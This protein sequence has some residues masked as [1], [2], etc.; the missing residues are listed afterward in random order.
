MSQLSAARGF[1]FR[2]DDPLPARERLRRAVA[3]LTRA[4]RTQVLVDHGFCG[5]L[6]GLVL[7]TVA[8]VAARL[9]SSPYPLW[10]LAGAAVVITL[11]IALLLGWRRRLNALDVAIRADLALKLK[12]RLSTAWEFMTVYGDNEL[13][14]RLAVQAVD[15]GLPDRPR[16]LFPLQV[17]RWGMLSPLA[18]AALLLASA[19]D[20]NLLHAPVPQEVDER[21]VG[22]GQRLGAFGRAMQE[23]ARRDELP[24]SAR[25]AAQIE[26][27]GARMEGGALSRSQALGE[28]RQMGDSL[29]Q[30]RTQALAEANATGGGSRH[31]ETRNGSPSVSDLNPESMLD[32]LRRGALDS[33]DTRALTGRLDDLERSGISRRDLENALKQHQ[34]GADDE[35]RKLLEK[36]ALIDRA[37]KEDR[38]LSG[39]R[40]QVRRAREN[41]GESVAGTDSG[42]DP[43]AAL[44]W[45]D[46]ENEDRG[47]KGSRNANAG[48][49]G[50]LNKAV[51]DAA[52]GAGSQGDSGIASNRQ[53]S[54]VRPGS[55][56][57]G[58]VLK[59]QGQLR[60]GEM[61]VS[62]GKIRPRA[63]RPSVENVKMSREFASQMEEV[64]S[65]EQYPVHYKEFIRRYFL[66]LSQGARVSQQQP[67]RTREE[68]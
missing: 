58:P 35:L 64:M 22:E 25:K 23:R 9:A 15:A 39:A 7:A 50:R 16:L 2:H 18:A 4:R 8:V 31:A 11:A 67:T 17:N 10:Q 54:R 27:L 34:A 24:R 43:S 46:E 48:E 37:L 3:E 49:N 42:R 68:P 66:S 19:I 40:E 44:D 57:S 65:K 26:R 60:E 36:L 59:A 62:E 56:P 12:Q 20:L 14:E 5:L 21:V 47:V 6:A 33:A 45:D 53:D 52:L 30:E 13:T 1:W 38:E 29:D 55:G 61:F 51:P 63:G 32:R 41:L 28:L